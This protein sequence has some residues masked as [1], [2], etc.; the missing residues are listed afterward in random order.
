[1]ERSRGLWVHKLPPVA[2]G[3]SR[4]G[5]GAL[6]RNP[7]RACPPAGGVFP[8]QF[9]DSLRFCDG[10]PVQS[11]Q[12]ASRR[13]PDFEDPVLAAAK[14]VPHLDDSVPGY[15]QVTPAARQMDS[16]AADLEPGKAPAPIAPAVIPVADQR[17]GDPADRQ[18]ART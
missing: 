3:D 17:G 8:D 1:M 9:T 6:L 11:D 10:E 14:R 7:W 15:G 16:F 4:T 5:S 18:R 2:T 13:I 12:V